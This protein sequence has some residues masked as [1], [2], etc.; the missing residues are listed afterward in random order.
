MVPSFTA[1]GR[2]P[3]EKIARRPDPEKTGRPPTGLLKNQNFR[4]PRPPLACF[5]AG[6]RRTRG[7][8]KKKTAHIQTEADNSASAA[9]R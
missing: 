5:R 7:V 2:P 1:A 3:L 4:P 8:K 6:K 9:A